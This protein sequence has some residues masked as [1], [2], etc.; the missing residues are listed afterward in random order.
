[1]KK[2]LFILS[3][4]LLFIF[5]NYLFLEKN[6]VGAII[7]FE[8]VP[9]GAPIDQLPITD[10]YK[11]VIDGGVTFS[12]DALINPWPVLE[13]IGSHPVTD[14]LNG[15]LND[16][17]GLLDTETPG[18]PGLPPGTPGLGSYFL[19]LSTLNLLS[20]PVP[21]L[22]ID[23]TTPVSATSAQ[24]WDIDMAVGLGFEQWLV[25]AKDDAGVTIATRL[26]P[27][28]ILWSDPNSLDGKPWFWSFNNPGNF[29]IWSIEI[30]W[31]GSKQSGIGL[32]FDNFNSNAV[33]IPGAIWL[34]GSGIL[35][36][37]FMRRK[38][39]N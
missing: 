9:G 17:S 19:R 28:G 15:F 14:P 7:N 22:I 20:T 39:K 37:V 27:Q 3:I 10:Q 31:M 1:M 29:N 13:V 11:N 25:T 6:A 23:Y 33:P 35:G 38:L 5:G 24:I 12:T 8:T 18:L 4:L 16:G 2:T 30:E 34:F 26:S 36:M 21:T 32:A